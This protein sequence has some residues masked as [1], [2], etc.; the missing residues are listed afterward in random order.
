MINY[1]ITLILF[2]FFS[3]AN[4]PLLNS[5]TLPNGAVTSYGYDSKG[6]KLTNPQ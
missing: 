6:K 4:I 3:F 1:L 2:S 5:V